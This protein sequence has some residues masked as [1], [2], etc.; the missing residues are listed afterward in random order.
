MPQQCGDLTF[1]IKQSF[2]SIMPS[3]FSNP[4]RHHIAVNG[5]MGISLTLLIC[6]TS[7]G[8][9]WAKP[10]KVLLVSPSTQEIFHPSPNSRMECRMPIH[11]LGLSAAFGGIL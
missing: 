6:S 2:T 1:Q 3:P 7:K 11:N 4:F 9:S 8:E 5:S 10:A